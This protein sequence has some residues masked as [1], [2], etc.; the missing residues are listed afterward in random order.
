VRIH[1]TTAL[2]AAG[3]NSD[4][5]F[6]ILMLA[7]R[8]SYTPG[9]QSPVEAVLQGI[10]VLGPK[11][12]KAVPRLLELLDKGPT[13]R[14]ARDHRVDALEALARIGPAAKAAVPRLQELAAADSILAAPA[15][16]ALAAVEGR[17]EPEL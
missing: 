5:Y 16:A 15:A 13:D 3:E 6:R 7:W 1:A 11:A 4:D 12:A 10:K 8:D 9:E 2:I 17:E 14:F